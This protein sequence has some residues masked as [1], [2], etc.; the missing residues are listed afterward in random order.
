MYYTITLHNSVN[1][2]PSNHL[3][4]FIFQRITFVTEIT[5]YLKDR[6][7]KCHLSFKMRKTA[8]GFVSYP[9]LFDNYSD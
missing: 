8:D 7:L 3:L 5:R 9:Q 4:F 2:Y 6:Y 1:P